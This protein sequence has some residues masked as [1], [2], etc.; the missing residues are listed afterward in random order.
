MGIAPLLL[1]IAIRLWV[2]SEEAQRNLLLALLLGG[3]LV[4]GYGLWD[5][6]AGG[7]VAADGVRRLVGPYFS[8]NHAALFLLRS[9]FLALVVANWRRNSRALGYGVSG[10]LLIG[11]LL[12]ASRGALLLGLPV[13][14]LLL[15]FL[16]RRP[17]EL[18]RPRANP[19]HAH[20]RLAW[21]A[22]VIITV[23]LFGI[24]VFLG[25]DRLANSATLLSRL[26]IW[27]AALRLW[28]HFPLFGVGADG[29]FW[30]YPA[31][32]SPAATPEV[33]LLHPHNLWLENATS[34]GIFGLFW[35]LALLVLLWKTLRKGDWLASGLCVAL[36]A[37]L[38]HA[39]VD[40][41][42]SL[43]DLAAWN[44][45]VLGLIQQ[46]T[47]DVGHTDQ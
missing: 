10:L 23:L 47:A 41:F 32:L 14:V 27:Q 35:L 34:C 43:P 29:F 2:R 20:V 36:I 33:N 44:W 3:T 38:A 6:L 39:Q 19:T 8:P 4:A 30:N 15:L 40:T 22:T 45:I 12:T 28:Q 7:G 1:Y 37:A 26:E 31:W 9:F 42:T 5:W 11:L 24:A 46:R 13:G 18:A 21:L 17:A 16:S 25:W